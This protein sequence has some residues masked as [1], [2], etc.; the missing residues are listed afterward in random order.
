MKFAKYILRW[1]IN[2]NLNHRIL[3]LRPSCRTFACTSSCPPPSTIVNAFAGTLVAR[4]RLPAASRPVSWVPWASV[5]QATGSVALQLRCRRYYA[6]PPTG[7][8]A[9]VRPSPS[10]NLVDELGGRCPIGGPGRVAPEV[11]RRLPLSHRLQCRLAP[12]H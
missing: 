2:E 4:L 8:S 6:S 10:L 7:P 3:Q 5:P 11:P 9:S 1:L 12:A